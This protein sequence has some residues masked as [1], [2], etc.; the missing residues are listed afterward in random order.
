MHAILSS[1]FVRNLL[2]RGKLLSTL[3]PEIVFT[4]FFSPIGAV[5]QGNFRAV[6]RKSLTRWKLQRP[7]FYGASGKDDLRACRSMTPV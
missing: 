3:W 6:T 4:Y 7:M 5:D 1:L 2:W